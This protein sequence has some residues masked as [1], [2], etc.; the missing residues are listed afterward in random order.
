M[1]AEKDTI[2]NKANSLKEIA[3]SIHQNIDDIKEVIDFFHY[4]FERS[5]EVCKAYEA[6]FENYTIIMNSVSFLKNAAE[7]YT[8]IDGIVENTDTQ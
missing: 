2:K 4:Y 6:F 1:L 8:F 5:H 7:N 3:E